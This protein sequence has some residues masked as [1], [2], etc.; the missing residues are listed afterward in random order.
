MFLYLSCKQPPKSFPASIHLF[1]VNNGSTKIMYLICSKLAIVN[2]PANIYLFKVNNR[3]TR[4]KCATCSKLSIKTPE[5]RQWR[6]SKVFIVSFEHI[7]HFFLALLLL[8]LSKYMLA[9][10]SLVFPGLLPFCEF[11]CFLLFPKWYHFIEVNTWFNNIEVLLFYCLIKL[12]H[13]PHIFFKYERHNHLRYSLMGEVPLKTY[14]LMKHTCLWP[15]KPIILW[16]MNR[17]A[18]ILLRTNAFYFLTR[19][20]QHITSKYIEEFANCAR[21]TESASSCVFFSIFYFSY[22][23]NFHFMAVVFFSI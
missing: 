21:A 3:N 7:W 23:R 10:T 20:P 5:Q 15:D 11:F 18:K 17:Q 13:C 12:L 4:K 8:P 22:P 1:K 6:R 9:G 16:T 14:S 19:F 2:N